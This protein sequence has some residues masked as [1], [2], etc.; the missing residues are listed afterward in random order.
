MP[1][2][3]GGV[4]RRANRAGPAA[5]TVGARNRADRVAAPEGV[6]TTTPDDAPARRG[7][8]TKAAGDR[9]RVQSPVA[10]NG[11]A[12]QVNRVAWTGWA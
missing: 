6:L 1:A 7:R 4:F 2:T 3:G 11:A 12:R 5:E 10:P 9:A 8:E